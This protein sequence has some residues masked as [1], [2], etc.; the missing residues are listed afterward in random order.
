MNAP[1]YTVIPVGIHTAQWKLREKV[2]SS[3]GQFY[4]YQFP[5]FFS[6]KCLNIISQLDG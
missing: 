6:V 5:E 3:L 1:K 4:C 2:I